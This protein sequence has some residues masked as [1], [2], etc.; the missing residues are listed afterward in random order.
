M[1]WVWMLTLELG[2]KDLRGPSLL[3]LG[4][5]FID[6]LSESLFIGVWFASAML[7]DSSRTVDAT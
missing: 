5:L 1:K 7:I 2:E 3:R 4:Y 6:G